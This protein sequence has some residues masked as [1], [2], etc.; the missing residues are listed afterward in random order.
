MEK[1]T[2][3][4]GVEGVEMLWHGE[5]ADPELRYDDVVANYNDV[6]DYLYSVFCDD[7]GIDEGDDRDE[8]FSEWCRR[9][10]WDVAGTIYECETFESK[11]NRFTDAV[12]GK[13]MYF[14]EP[15]SVDYKDVTAV[16]LD[17]DN[18]RMFIRTLAGDEIELENVCE[19]DRRSRQFYNYFGSKNTERALINAYSRQGYAVF[20]W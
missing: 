9:H 19:F 18:W 7:L 5:W 3:W 10:R 13:W 2:Y 17:S 16:R 14:T 15:V 4:R 20:Q 11:R 6:E 12:D 1:K 8:E